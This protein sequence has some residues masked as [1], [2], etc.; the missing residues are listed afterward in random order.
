MTK[1]KINEMVSIRQRKDR[2]N[3]LRA[4]GLLICYCGKCEPEDYSLPSD[5]KKI[6]DLIKI[7]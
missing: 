5:F 2:P 1:L 4:N 7:K 6:K 3:C